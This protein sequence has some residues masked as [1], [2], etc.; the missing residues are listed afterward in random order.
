MTSQPR[1]V[2]YFDI[3]SIRPD[4]LGCYGYHRPTSPVIDRVAR[5][6]VRFDV[7]YTSDGPCM[8]SRCATFSGRF[9]VHTGVVTHGARGESIRPGPPMIPALLSQAGMRTCT[10]SSFG[11]HPAPWFYA[12]WDETLDPASTQHFQRNQSHEVNALAEDWL[13][14][15]ANEN[16]FLH[17]QY[18]DPHVPYDLPESV[19]EPFYQYEPLDFP[20]EEMIREHIT[21]Y[22]PMG[23]LWYKLRTV[24]D[25]HRHL[26]RYDAQIRYTDDYIGRILDLLDQLGIL[27]ETFIVITGDHGEQ[28]GEYNVYQD[29]AIACEASLRVPLI[30]RAPA[31]LPQGRVLPGPVYSQDAI[32]T[33][34]EYCGIPAEEG[35]DFRS[36]LPVISGQ[37]PGRDFVVSGHGLYSGGRCIRT[38]EWMLRKVYH[39]GF[40]RLPPWSLF[41]IDR[42][43]HEQH[44]C[45]RDFPHVFA[46][47]CNR[48]EEWERAQGPRDADPMVNL[49]VEGPF[50]YLKQIV[51]LDLFAKDHLP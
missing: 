11:R 36:L 9:G 30:L 2:I 40:W 16:F 39:P 34:L 20:T 26:Q 14:R 15:H 43:P 10:I 38:R 19:H 25:V 49:A 41:R 46:E 32:R 50:S 27:D 7:A 1:R 29:H 13:R 47:L 17:L 44:D 45:L 4:H 21:S 35:Y 22:D 3:D 8:P 31:M 23:A 48:L 42:D 28:Q 33:I 6:G 12:P 5:E 37:D 18:W 24:Q 51:T